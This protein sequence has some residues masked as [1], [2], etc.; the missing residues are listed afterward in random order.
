MNNDIIVDR[1]QT[2]N[3]R[4][5]NDKIIQILF[6]LTIPLVIQGQEIN[7][8]FNLVDKNFPITKKKLY[9]KVSAQK[10]FINFKKNIETI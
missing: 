7:T 6:N 3:L 8:E 2:V 5:I 9:N 4:G 10:V 1:T